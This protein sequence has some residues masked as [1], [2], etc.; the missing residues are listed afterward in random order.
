M[1]RYSDKCIEI[2]IEFNY[3]SEGIMCVLHP[4]HIIKEFGDL[5]HDCR[6]SNVY[7][8]YNIGKSIANWIV[9]WN[10][11]VTELLIN[12]RLNNTSIS[13]YNCFDHVQNTNSSS[14][15]KVYNSTEY[16]HIKFTSMNITRLTH[17][18]R[19]F[20]HDIFKCTFL[21][22]NFRISNHMF[23]RV[24]LTIYRHCFR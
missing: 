18:G 15:R 9:K 12:S 3:L 16:I 10:V 17:W 6:G 1:R 4:K 8:W 23:R 22:E 19:N 14:C 11:L 7:L 5:N 24:Q 13:S 2:N 21:N 20:A